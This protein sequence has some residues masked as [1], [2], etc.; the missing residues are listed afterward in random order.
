MDE[1]TEGFLKQQT[2]EVKVKVEDH[3][4]QTPWSRLFALTV[5]VF[6]GFTAHVSVPHIYIDNTLG[7]WEDVGGMN[8]YSV[9]NGG[10][11]LHWDCFGCVVW[12]ERLF[13]L[14]QIP[15][16]NDHISTSGTVMLL[17]EVSF[18]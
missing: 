9:K 16:I 2:E 4:Q 1:S 18:F 14:N 13:L 12:E 3:G 10:P 8:C 5:T 7:E 15:L 17:L 6:I 11:E